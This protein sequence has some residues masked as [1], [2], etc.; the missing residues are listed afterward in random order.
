MVRIARVFEPRPEN[1]ETY[2]RLFA[3]FMVCQKT[4]KPVFHALNRAG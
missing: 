4:L 2:D 1:R 3:Q